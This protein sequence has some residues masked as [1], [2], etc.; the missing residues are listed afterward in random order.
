MSLKVA[1]R[2][3][4]FKSAGLKLRKNN[5]KSQ[6]IGRTQQASSSKFG[7]S[8]LFIKVYSNVLHYSEFG[9]LKDL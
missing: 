8:L 5:Y 9:W 7:D 1:V 3:Y 6:L 4:F 2:I